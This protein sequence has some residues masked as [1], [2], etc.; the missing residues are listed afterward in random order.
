MCGS[1]SIYTQ[2][3]SAPGAGLFPSSNQL[4]D[5]PQEAAD[6]GLK[7]RELQRGS[8]GQEISKD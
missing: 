3:N 7:L 2:S 6:T 8:Y 5:S 4:P 1:S